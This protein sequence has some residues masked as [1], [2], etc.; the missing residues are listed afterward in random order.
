MD[1]KQALKWIYNLKGSEHK[2]GF[3]LSLDAVKVLLG[4]LNNPEKELKV[5][6][7]TGTNGKGSVCAMVA[8]VLKKLTTK[9]GCIPP[10]I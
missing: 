10:L 1:Y 8:S 3:N 9:L 2:G 4:K 5:V 6:H 7:V